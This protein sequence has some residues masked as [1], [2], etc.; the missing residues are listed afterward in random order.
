ML[1]GVWLANRVLRS[2]PSPGAAGAALLILVVGKSG[3]LSYG[4]GASLV[5]VLW[6]ALVSSV[7]YGM[8]MTVLAVNACQSRDVRRSA[9]SATLYAV[10][11]Q[12]GASAGLASLDAL[13]HRQLAAQ[14]QVSLTHAYDVVFVSEAALAL[15]VLPFLLL[16]R[17][18]PSHAVP[19]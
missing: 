1:L 16:L 4:V 10:A 11:T 3:F 14:A 17:A 9:A 2:V 18:R 8:L 19:S 13:L 15:L 12:V 7:G 6:P 5:T